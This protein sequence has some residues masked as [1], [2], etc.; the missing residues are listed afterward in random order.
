LFVENAVGPIIRVDAR[1]DV[2]LG[3]VVGV[4]PDEAYSGGSVGGEGDG[5][6]GECEDSWMGLP[7]DTVGVREVLG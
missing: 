1:L 3:L 7:K 6:C 2:G 4:N 5:W